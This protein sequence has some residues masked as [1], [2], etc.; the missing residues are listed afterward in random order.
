MTLGPLM[1]DVAGKTLAPED[2]EVLAHP[3]VGSVI[4]FTRNYADPAQLAALVAEIRAVR[5]PP[6]LVAVDHEGGRVQRFREGFS[7]IPSM[8]RVGQEFDLNPK[9][10]VRIEPMMED[11]YYAGR[12][13]GLSLVLKF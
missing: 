12:S 11:N 3:L 1:I 6:L 13:T 7:R 9:L 2:R 10:R 8:R 4:L 5:S